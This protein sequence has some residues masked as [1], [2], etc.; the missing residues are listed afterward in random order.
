MRKL[1]IETHMPL[2]SGDLLKYNQYS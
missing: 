1:N 2:R